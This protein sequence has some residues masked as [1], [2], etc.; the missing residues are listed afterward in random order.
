MKYLPLD[1]P[2]EYLA[3]LIA[4][5]WDNEGN[6]W[7]GAVKHAGVVYA[8]DSSVT[9]HGKKL[10]V[11]Q[12]LVDRGETHSEGFYGREWHPLSGS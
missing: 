11:G 2:G 9:A 4:T 1:E 7:V 8:E 5:Y 12:E 10:K 6:L 3:K